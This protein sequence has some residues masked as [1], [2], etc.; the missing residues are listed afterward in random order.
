VPPSSPDHAILSPIIAPTPT[1]FEDNSDGVF[2]VNW[3]KDCGD[4]DEDEEDL[5]IIFHHGSGRPTGEWIS[6]LGWV[7]VGLPMVADCSLLSLD[8]KRRRCSSRGWQA[9]AAQV[10]KVS[11]FF[12]ISS[13]PLLILPSAFGVDTLGSF[14][15]ALGE[16]ILSGEISIDGLE[17]WGKQK[18]AGIN[19]DGLTDLALDVLCAPGASFFFFL[20]LI[21]P[22]F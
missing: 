16:N 19:H 4:E 2:D 10:P 12:V 11:D 5:E 18:M 9:S 17:W 6:F 13:F 1:D 20:T 14:C 7:L 22:W 15:H 8:R 21:Q 3:C